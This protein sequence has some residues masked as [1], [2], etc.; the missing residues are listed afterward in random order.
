M[1]KQAMLFLNKLA[2]YFFGLLFSWLLEQR[3]KATLC[4]TKVLYKKDYNEIVKNRGY[5]GD[6]DPFGDFDLLFGAA[7]NNLKIIEV[8]VLYAERK[9]GEIKIERFKHGMLL[10]KMSFIAMK[11]LT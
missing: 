8:P 7:K 10:I 5:F 3:I 1:E 6:F 9:Y 11:K 2:N 4:G